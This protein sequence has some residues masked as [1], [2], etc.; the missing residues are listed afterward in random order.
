MNIV[1]LDKKNKCAHIAYK[2]KNIKTVPL[3]DISSFLPQ[4]DDDIFYVKSGYLVTKEQL[5]QIFNGQLDL[6]AIVPKTTKKTETKQPQPSNFA[7]KKYIHP[8]HNGTITIPDIDFSSPRFPNGLIE[9]SGKWDFFDV[10]EVGGM[11]VME[12]SRHFQILLKNNKIVVADYDFYIKNKDKHGKIKKSVADQRVEADLLPS[13][14]KARDRAMGID[15][16]DDENLV[17]STEEEKAGIMSE[18]EDIEQNDVNI[19]IE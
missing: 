18:T 12:E 15:E 2:S 6:D 3:T 17:E 19:F 13:N 11:S 7:K 16:W 5:S 4:N 1:F 14:V 9:L 8:K 10:D